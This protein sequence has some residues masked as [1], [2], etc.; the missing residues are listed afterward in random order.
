MR[1][2]LPLI[3]VL[4]CFGCASVLQKAKLQHIR[5]VGILS[6]FTAERIPE[7]SGQGVLRQLDLEGKLQ[8]AEDA[9]EVFQ[10]AFD[11]LGWKVRETSEVTTNAV[12][13]EGLAK[14]PAPN[15]LSGK[16]SNAFAARYF[17]PPSMVAVWLGDEALEKPYGRSLIKTD[18]ALLAETM[19]D[20]GIDTGVLLRT[21]YCFRTFLRGKKERLVVTCAAGVQLVNPKGE[22]IFERELPRGCGNTPFSESKK[23][24][25]ISSEDWTYDPLQREAI[26]ELFKE[27]SEAES[28]RLVRSI[29]FSRRPKQE[30]K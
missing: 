5:D 26:R 30:T 8:I 12:Y 29:P 28:K 3:S 18:S 9:L 1:L 24:I 2:W 20:L 19:A 13:A 25:P 11:S 27:A 4:I 14:K 16:A 15:Y 23:S 7:S 6:F 22:K 10:E 17:S 21:Q